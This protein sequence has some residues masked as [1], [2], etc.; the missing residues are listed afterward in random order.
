MAEPK[1]SN[2]RLERL[3]Q[4][5][6]ELKDVNKFIPDRS[7]YLN[8][9]N[10]LYDLQ[11]AKGSINKQKNLQ[12]RITRLKSEL[13]SKYIQRN[14]LA[15]SNLLFDPL[16]GMTGSEK[17]KIRNPQY[18]QKYDPTSEE[19]LRTPIDKKKP[20][21]KDGKWVIPESGP[22][23]EEIQKYSPGGEKSLFMRDGS[24]QSTDYVGDSPPSKMDQYIDSGEEEDPYKAML[25]IS[26]DSGLTSTT[27]P[28][29]QVS[30]EYNRFTEKGLNQAYKDFESLTGKKPSIIQ[31]KLI[32]GGWSPQE[33]WKKIQ[34]NRGG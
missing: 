15:F 13:G 22:N 30:G 8:Q 5:E 19:S 23:L 18:V 31:E 16:P 1:K 6:A 20:V 11:G 26:G 29:S 3:K 10:Y 14:K 25:R 21:F 24:L 28:S 9:S 12:K 7:N 2:W 34:K 32:Q 27:T 4:L 17:L 33:L